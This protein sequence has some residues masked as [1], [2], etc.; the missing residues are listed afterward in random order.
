[1]TEQVSNMAEQVKDS[2][3]VSVILT[4]YNGEKYIA[5]TLESVLN[6]TYTNL[7][8]IIVDDASTDNTVQIIKSYN[9]KRIKLYSNDKNLGIGHNT[10]R[11]LS[12]ATGE[13]IMMQDHDDISSPSRAE[14]QLKCLIDHPDVTGIT[15][16]ARRFKDTPPL[17][18]YNKLDSYHIDKTANE[19]NAILI[20]TYPGHQ[21]LFYRRSILDKL[22]SWYS[23]KFI[24][25]GDIYFM[26]K[27]NQAGAKWIL[28]NDTLL[29]YR[30]H[31]TM[32]TKKSIDPQIYKDRLE[33]SMITIRGYLPDISDSDALMHAKLIQK[34]ELLNI[35]NISLVNHFKRI[36]ALNANNDFCDDNDL[37]SDT[38]IKFKTASIFAN[39]YSPIK[40]YKV[41]RSIDELKPY[42]VSFLM[43]LKEHQKRFFRYIFNITDNSK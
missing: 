25:D 20:Y 9:D 39:M 24:V 11:A 36:L 37:K 40:A 21:T 4:T 10:N 14:L 29:A 38:A 18:I 16:H 30:I 1:M 22:D 6:Q 33:I 12:L 28:L 17:E 35:D 23:D 19:F 42:T 34:R 2:P 5:E 7:E 27:L 32:T 3:L 15:L 43:F 13:F 41:Y 8:I 31:S 26:N